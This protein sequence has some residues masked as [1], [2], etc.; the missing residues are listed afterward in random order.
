MNKLEIKKLLLIKRLLN[1]YVKPYTKKLC[2][3]ISFMI[4]FAATNTAHVALIKPALDKVFLQK[5]PK[6][7]FYIPLAVIIIG[8]I[9]GGSAFYQNYLMKYIGQRIINDI[10]IILYQH[11]LVSDLKILNQQSSGKLISK[12]TNDLVIIK[13]NITSLLTGLIKELL[14]VIFLIGLM[15]Y[16]NF[17]LAVVAFTVFPLAILPIIKISKKIRKISMNMQEEF[18]KYTAHL[19]ETFRSIRT[20][21]SYNR[22]EFEVIK[23]QTI[24]NKIFNLYAKAVKT[25]SLSS[26]L[27]ETL[28]GIGIGAT[29]FYGGN[30]VI[31]GYSSTG[32]FFTFIMAFI[33]SY[34]PL[35]TLINLNNNLQETLIA[36]AR[37]FNL[38]DT[39]S[40]IKDQIDSQNILTN[41]AKLQLLNVDFS[42]E[43]K[44]NLSKLNLLVN[45]GQTVAI[46]G[47]SGSGK[48]TIANLILRLYD[49]DQGQVLINDVNVKQISLTSL[50]NLIAVVSQEVLLF[51]DTILNNIRYGKLDATQEQIIEAARA[52]VADEFINELPLA[53][54]TKI[55]QSGLKLSGGQR[56][57]IAI[58]RALLKNS[59]VLLLDEATSSLDPIIER[60]IQNNLFSLRKGKTNIIIA[61]RLSTIINADLIYVIDH[62]KVVEHGTHTELLNNKSMYYQLY[63]Q[64]IQED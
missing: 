6:M 60:K 45:S 28:A 5:D 59:P 40:T 12:F 53:Y 8:I 55:G 47:T 11:L 58:A 63:N 35:K 4:I 37:L 39:K 25:D 7:L 32:G 27:M 61:H 52:A 64:Q 34:K 2:L 23:A 21:K 30:Q 24:I 33:A 18:S 13:N 48:S 41:T 31:N 20:I 62:G 16:E 46:V 29:I 54:E 22:E 1:N 42:Y 26:P 44:L 56:Q 57:R 51:D 14:T 19:D 49:V 10:Q 36:T 38:L 15:F 3:A 9:K 50:R 43:D 17:L